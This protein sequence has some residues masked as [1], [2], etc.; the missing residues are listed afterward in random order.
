MSKVRT[1]PAIAALLFFAGAL[2]GPPVKSQVKAIQKALA[3]DTVTILIT[4]SGLGGLAVVADIEK[5]ARERK[6]YRSMRLLFC[7]AL[8]EAGQGYNR[9]P[10]GKRKA[11]VFSAALDGM[12]RAFSPDAVLVACNTLSVVYHDTE[13]SHRTEVPVL[14][15]VDIGIQMLYERLAARE[16]TAGV[17][18]G[19]ETT[20]DS[21][22]HRLLLLERGIRAGSLVTE[23]CPDLAGEIEVDPSSDPV[24]TM[25]DFFASDASSRLPLDAT[26]VVAGLCC[27]HY[28]YTA[29]EFAEAIRRHSRRNVEIVDPTRQM[30]EIV[31]PPDRR[32][33]FVD[34]EVTVEVISRAWISPA[35]GISIGRLLEPVSPATARALRHY[36]LDLDLFPYQSEE[37]SP[38]L[39]EHP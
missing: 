22:T 2:L 8:P 11:E 32:T 13:F 23:A 14:G 30:A 12:V 5:A 33:R 24:R 9:M 36:R 18:F 35:E 29:E 21:D 31:F 4:D 20:I 38:E 3:R 15:I 7:N 37:H 28:A 26:T 17:I 27:T 10:S 1:L 6:V 25:I 19:T 39:Q 16:G 34:A